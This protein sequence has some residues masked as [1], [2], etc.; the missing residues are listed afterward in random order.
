MHG[1]RPP[2]A[3]FHIGKFRIGHSKPRCRSQRRHPLE[4][5][6]ICNVKR[7]DSHRRFSVAR[8]V[9]HRLLPAVA[10]MCH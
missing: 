5:S 1:A 3:P 4:S 10:Q 8:D 6:A 7:H 2:A 9:L